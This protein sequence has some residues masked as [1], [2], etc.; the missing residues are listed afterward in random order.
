MMLRPPRRVR[1]H[2]HA[3]PSAAPG[4][5]K[6]RVSAHEPGQAEALNRAFV[7]DDP[8]TRQAFRCSSRAPPAAL[9]RGV[10]LGGGG[11]ATHAGRAPGHAH[12]VRGR[13]GDL[14][15]ALPRRLR[16]PAQEHASGPLARGDPGGR[17]RGGADVSGHRAEGGALLSRRGPR[18]SRRGAALPPGAHAAGAPRR[19]R[20]LRPA[21]AATSVSVNSV[22]GYVRSVYEKLHVHTK[23]AAV[24]K[25]LGAG[26]I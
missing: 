2:E 4:A 21:A 9:R 25:A 12:R 3:S 20:E 19:R 5:R 14:R 22:R 1:G 18:G 23:S 24:A 16:L 26:L 15:L 13:G 11:P 17:R 7:E 8:A 6:E 10:G